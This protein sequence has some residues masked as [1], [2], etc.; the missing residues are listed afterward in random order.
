VSRWSFCR[1]IVSR[2]SRRHFTRRSAGACGGAR[3]APGRWAHG[4]ASGAARCQ[5][6]RA[7]CWQCGRHAVLLDLLR[8]P[9]GA[10]RCPAG[11]RQAPA[12][13]AV[14][15][16]CA[17]LLCCCARLPCPAALLPWCAARCAALLCDARS[18]AGVQQAQ[19]LRQLQWPRGRRLGQGTRRHARALSAT[20]R[21]ARACISGKA[22]DGMHVHA[23]DCAGS[24]KARESRDGMRVSCLVCMHVHVRDGM[25]GIPSAQHSTRNAVPRREGGPLASTGLLPDGLLCCAEGTMRSSRAPIPAQ[26]D[27]EAPLMLIQ[28]D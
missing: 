22:R 5:Q 4:A 13:A 21:D 7:P 23:R 14:L 9:R 18:C 6:H 20:T 11:L 10:A 26:L 15:P 8:T 25:R 27:A 28:P 19:Q 2:K 16:C 1:P 3:G 17:V 24:G 12:G